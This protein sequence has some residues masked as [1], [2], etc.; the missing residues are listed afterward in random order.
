MKRKITI[1]TICAAMLSTLPGCRLAR[2]DAGFR[3]HEDRLIGMFITTEF[4]DLFDFEGFFNQNARNMPIGG[5][6]SGVNAENFQGRIYASLVSRTLSDE[7]NNPV[8]EIYEFM[9]EGIE[10]FAI[11]A[12]MIPAADDRESHIGVTV[13]DAVNVDMWHLQ[14]GDDETSATIEGTIA[15]SSAAGATGFFFNPVYQSADGHVFLT[16]GSGISVSGT[17]CEGSVF[18]QKIESTV[19]VTENGRTT[20]FS[21]SVQVN[22]KTMFVPERFV[23]M[24]MDADGNLINRSSYLAEDFP[25]TVIPQAGME[26]I[27]IETVRYAADG[28]ARV[29]R[30]IYGRDSDWIYIFRAG[31]SGVLVRALTRIEWA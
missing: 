31:D 18:S 15:V 19:T 27:I 11:F 29:L 10:G 23:I 28:A 17:Q 22:I 16:S 13:D 7:G 14:F 26:F 24:Q 2:E 30:E 3:E 5:L 1:I 20:T 4:L 12:P 8:S 25:D 9:F 6:I 21:S